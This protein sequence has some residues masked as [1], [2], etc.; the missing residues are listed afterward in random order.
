[1]VITISEM[2]EKGSGNAV[3]S[4]IASSPKTAVAIMATRIDM[5]KSPEFFTITLHSM[6]PVA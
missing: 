4:G 3:K 2:V 6:N 1:M 5:A